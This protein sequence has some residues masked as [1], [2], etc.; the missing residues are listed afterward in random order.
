[1]S[2]IRLMH[3]PS[4]LSWESRNRFYKNSLEKMR[5]KGSRHN[6]AFFLRVVYHETP[7]GQAQ[8]AQT[9]WLGFCKGGA[10]CPQSGR[11][12]V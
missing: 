3:S 10:Q 6:T 12:C 1:M 2:Q 7:R 9:D 8:R 11:L 5:R 4:F